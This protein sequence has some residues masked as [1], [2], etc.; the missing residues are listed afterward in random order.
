VT[1]DKPRRVSGSEKRQ[2]DKLA[3]VR[4]TSEE[5]A[6][7]QDAARRARL[8]L[9][10]YIRAQ[11]LGASP[12]RSV[13]RPPVEKELLARILGQLGKAGSNLNQVAR[14]ANMGRETMED[15]RAALAEVRLAAFAVQQ[16][17]GRQP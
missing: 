3:Q 12:P 5:L 6:K 13:R 9:A 14:A 1:N 10:S 11:M 2:R 8:T 4:L 15:V 16:A 17:L 7:A